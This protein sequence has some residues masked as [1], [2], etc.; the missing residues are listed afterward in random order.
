[1]NVIATGQHFPEVCP[2]CSG[3]TTMTS[4][5]TEDHERYVYRA[6]SCC[7]GFECDKCGFAWVEVRPGREPEDS[8][9][10]YWAHSVFVELGVLCATAKT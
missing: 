1:L 2:A 3:K 8:W 4:M 5:F 10:E 9:T 7:H 6:D